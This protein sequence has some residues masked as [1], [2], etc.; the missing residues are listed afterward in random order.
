MSQL[1]KTTKTHRMNARESLASLARMRRYGREFWLELLAWM[2]AE[3][4]VAL[5]YK[6]A[7]DCLADRLERTVRWAQALLAAARVM[8]ETKQASPGGELPDLGQRACQELARLPTADLR[9]EIFAEAQADGDTSA[10]AMRELVD[11]RLEEVE[12]QAPA[13]ADGDKSSTSR[14]P[15]RTTPATSGTDW[16][17]RAA[18]VAAK[19][20]KINHHLAGRAGEADRRLDHYLAWLQGGR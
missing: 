9:R 20:R 14:S 15:A 12:D 10:A 8:H 11:S 17:A 13:P 1:A 3:G 4:W 5:G 7:S 19:L 16:H 2:E 6:Y 18:K